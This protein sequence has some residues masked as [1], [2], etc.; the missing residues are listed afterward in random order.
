MRSCTEW[1][2]CTSRG[3]T[4]LSFFSAF[5]V[6]GAVNW[7]CNFEM[8]VIFFLRVNV[9]MSRQRFVFPVEP[10]FALGVIGAVTFLTMVGV[11]SFQ[12]Y[13]NYGKVF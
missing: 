6:F 10:L 9:T 11:S 1:V 12:K 8:V 7:A 2:V 4:G 13:E 5:T 3:M